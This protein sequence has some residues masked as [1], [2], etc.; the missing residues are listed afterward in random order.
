MDFEWD[1]DKARTNEVKHGVSFP[2]AASVFGDP[3]AVTFD[4]PLR[5]ADE[6]RYLTIGL[7]ATGRVLIVSHTDREAATRII[8]AGGQP[9]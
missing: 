6:D 3:L 4:D 2:E 8:S 5:S 9:R 7:S 1:E